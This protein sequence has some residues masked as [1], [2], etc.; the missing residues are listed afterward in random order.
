MKN[1]IF[2]SQGSELSIGIEVFLKSFSC[3]NYHQKSAFH[4]FC[5]EDFFKSQMNLLNFDFSIVGDKVIFSGGSLQ[6][7]FIPKKK[8]TGQDSLEHILSDISKDDVLLTLPMNKEELYF[9]E[10]LCSGHTEYFRNYFNLNNLSMFFESYKDYVLLLSD[11]TPLKDV[12]SNLLQQDNFTKIFHTLNYLGSDIQ[13]VIFSGINPH[14]GE[15]GTLGT[16]ES[17]FPVLIKKLQ[18]EFKNITFY[19]P[20]PSDTIY[21]LRNSKNNQLFIFAYHDQGLNTFKERNRFLGLNI[22][23]GLP[24]KRL[25]VDHGTAPSIVGKNVANYECSLLSLHKSLAMVGW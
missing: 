4:L 14:A 20:V 13:E 17:L 10:N 7:S 19:G 3:L 6:V 8:S 9:A 15:N 18:N 12:C 2:V 5:N 23:L 22:T 16:E 24:F 21:Q 11:H 25:S 1:T